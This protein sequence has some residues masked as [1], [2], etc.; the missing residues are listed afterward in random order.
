MHSLADGRNGEVCKR[1]P[2]YDLTEPHLS[3]CATIGRD[4][5]TSEINE[6]PN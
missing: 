6:T 4:S 5:F 2:R 1:W 3:L